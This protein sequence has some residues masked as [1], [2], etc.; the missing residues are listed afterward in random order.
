M[1]TSYDFSEKLQLRRKIVR[2]LVRGKK[3]SYKG[4]KVINDYSGI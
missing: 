1:E 3:E 2:D 4:W